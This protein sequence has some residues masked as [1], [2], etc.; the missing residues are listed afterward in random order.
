MASSTPII[1]VLSRQNYEEQHIVSL[2]NALPLPSLKPSSL[3]VQSSLLSLT[4]NNLTYARIGHLLGWWDFHPLPSSIPAEFSDPKAY[5]RISA[6]GYGTVVESTATGIEVGTQIYGYLP[7]GTLPVDMKVDFDPAIPG[8]VQEISEHRSKLLP[9]YNR[10]FFHPKAA[11]AQDKDGQAYDSL[12]RVLF[13]TGFMINRFVF[14]WE[15]SEVVHPGAAGGTWT[16]EN[17]RIDGATILLFSASGKTSLSLAHQLKYGRPV[18]Q[19]P[20]KV[21]AVGS[22]FSKSFTEGTGLYDQVLDYA[23]DEHDLEKELGLNS[24]SRIVVCEFGSRDAAAA[25]YV[26]RVW[27]Y[28]YIESHKISCSLKCFQTRR[29]QVSILKTR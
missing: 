26:F 3:R 14:A 27:L 8:R 10:Y 7:I 21:V 1:Q 18:S 11:T 15:P 16:Y 12:V 4:T 28:L 23:A 13:E 5:G 24:G 9:I 22:K 20:A 29:I 19:K 6:W 2:P 17:A 25:R